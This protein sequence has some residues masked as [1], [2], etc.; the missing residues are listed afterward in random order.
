MNGTSAGAP[1]M[2]E[3]ARSHRC[4]GRGATR[5]KA[6][7]AL[8]VVLVAALAA[9]SLA[10]GSVV[11]HSALEPTRR[12]SAA[13]ISATV[14]TDWIVDADRGT[15]RLLAYGAARPLRRVVVKMVPVEDG[16]PIDEV[17]ADLSAIDAAA[18]EDYRV[19]TDGPDVWGGRPAYNVD[20]AYIDAGQSDLPV[21]VRGLATYVRVGRQ[22]AVIVVEADSSAYEAAWPTL[23]E[24]RRSVSVARSTR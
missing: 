17:A 4:C 8:S 18:L 10:V 11:R 22:V 5:A 20:Y 2:A 7:E 23:D 14:P 12:I 1:A 13:T 15:D 19:L 24:V 16:S 6:E 21:V 9:L 3:E